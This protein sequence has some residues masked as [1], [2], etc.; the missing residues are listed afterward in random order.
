MARLTE[1]TAQP[2]VPFT[3]HLCMH[4]ALP[5]QFPLVFYCWFPDVSF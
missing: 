2:P 4:A 1:K 5:A 3:Y